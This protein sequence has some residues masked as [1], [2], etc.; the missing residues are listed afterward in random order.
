VN[1]GTSKFWMFSLTVYG[2]AAVQ[3]E[4]LDLQDGYGID[5]NLLLF[6]AFIGV[7]HG[8]VLSDQDVKDA[9]DLVNAW[10]E[11]VVGRL[12]EVRR[13]LKPRASETS[14][15]ARLRKGIKA[16][17][18]NAERI[19]QA[20]LERWSVTRIDAWPRTRPAGAVVDNIRT[21]F[22]ISAATPRPDL[23]SHLVAAALALGGN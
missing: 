9:T 2:D 3:Q 14:P 19:E 15:A 11:N 12:R 22:A 21:L 7:I 23:P 5:V 17:E 8:A 13:A 16:L 1:E 20:M 6:C 4:C 18:L 10:H